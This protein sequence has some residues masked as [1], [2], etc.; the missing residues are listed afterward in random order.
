MVPSSLL[1]REFLQLCTSCIFS[2]LGR[3]ACYKIVTTTYLSES[4]SMCILTLCMQHCSVRQEVSSRPKCSHTPIPYCDSRVWV[5]GSALCIAGVSNLLFAVGNPMQCFPGMILSIVHRPDNRYYTHLW[6]H[7][8][9]RFLTKSVN[10]LRGTSLYRHNTTFPRKQ[11]QCWT[12]IRHTPALIL[13]ACHKSYPPSS[14]SC[15][16]TGTG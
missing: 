6:H 1:N 11:R 16:G 5:V 14:S 7:T 15:M 9:W 12:C 10:C 4:L 8:P 13:E 2:V 3:C